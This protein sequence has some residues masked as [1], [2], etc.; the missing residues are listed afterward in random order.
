M[1]NEG[2]AKVRSGEVYE[3]AEAFKRECEGTRCVC[4]GFAEL[5][6]STAEET[7]TRCACCARAFVCILCG[8]RIVG[9]AEAPEME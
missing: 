3:S 4:G 7:K 2:E 5:V 8:L 6:D 9:T 1:A